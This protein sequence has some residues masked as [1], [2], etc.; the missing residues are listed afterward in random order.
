LI[1]YL[2][3]LDVRL[4]AEGERLRISA[5][6]G[7]LTE[8]Q[9]A[10][11]AERK[12]EILTLLRDRT[13]SKPSCFAPIPRRPTHDPSP[14][15]FAQERLW[16]L[17]QLEPGSTV[18]NI[19]RGHRLTGPLNIPALSASVSEIVRRHQA[20]RSVFLTIDGQPR[21]VAAPAPK[22]A[23]PTFD[24]S[25]L[26]HVDREKEVRRKL[27]EEAKRPFDVSAGLFL[28]GMVLRL[29]PDEHILILSTHHIVF[30]AWS[31]GILTVEL[32]TLYEA[33]AA[34]KPSPLKELPIQYADFA[35][36]QRVQLGEGV[37]NSQIAYWKEQLKGI[38]V[39]DLPTDR[40]RPPRQSF[41]G[42]RITIML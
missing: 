14:L 16:F 11:L 26:A 37:L 15:S 24:F 13:I 41:D 19:C 6:R 7:A 20:L 42:A 35:V 1:S 21:Q 2:E 36:W 5:P 8:E 4:S 40:P 27:H 34:D 32:W 30:D 39:L 31:M 10:Q 17:E 18:Y 29:E 12:R 28:R 25:A 9:R 38:P 33:Y 3:A 22:I 23:L